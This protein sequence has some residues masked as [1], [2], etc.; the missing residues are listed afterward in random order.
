[1]SK[2]LQ[3]GHCTDALCLAVRTNAFLKTKMGPKLELCTLG[4]NCSFAHSDKE[5]RPLPEFKKT[6]ICY[7]FRRGRC[8]DPRCKFAHGEEDMMGYIPQ[9]A[10]QTRR[11][12]PYNLVGACHDPTCSQAHLQ[13]RRA[14]SRLKTFLIALRNALSTTK[15]FGESPTSVVN[16]KKRLKGG[17]PWQSLG[18]S[19]FKEAVLFLPGTDFSSDEHLV[20][21]HGT[22]QTREL[23]QRLH[24]MVD[25]QKPTRSL[26]SLSSVGSVAGESFEVTTPIG[27][28]GQ[29][30]TSTISPSQ[31]V[32]SA[33]FDFFTCPVCE[34]LAVDPVITGKCSHVM[35]LPCCE[36]WKGARGNLLSCPRCQTELTGGEVEVISSE[37]SST[38]AA[39]LAVIY[40]SIQ[41]RC[42]S[43]S[44]IGSPRSYPVHECHDIHVEPDDQG[45][46]TVVTPKCATMV[47]VSDFD[48]P[49]SSSNVIPVRKGD[50]V[51]LTAESDSGWALVTK[52]ATHQRGW[53]PASYLKSADDPPYALTHSPTYSA[54]SLS[55]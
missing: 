28:F 51:E 2:R 38:T 18:F 42:E 1:M 8:F 39:A 24:E 36:L 23:I 54:P 55:A 33:S 47:A 32:G 26:S 37:S 7:N 6:A 3:S 21:L 49:F 44:W 15:P 16:L 30:L 40:D 19:S 4:K 34:G 35:C 29:F 10:V 9:P 20:M 11:I 12:C 41:V 5:L 17:I 13:S 22:P 31:V 14:A 43:C 46:L 48:T 52:L 25:S 50:L 45:G 27:S 53:T